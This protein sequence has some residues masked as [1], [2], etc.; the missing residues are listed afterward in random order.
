MES[1]DLYKNA[2]ISPDKFFK[3]PL[4][5]LGNES[6]SKQQKIEVLK[7]WKHDALELETADDENMSTNGRRDIMDEV[8][9]ALRLLEE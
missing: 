2:L 7:R 5:V 6:L 9:E 3:K 1:E 4:D 8:V